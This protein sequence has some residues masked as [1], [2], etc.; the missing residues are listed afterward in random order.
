MSKISLLWFRQLSSI[1]NSWRKI[2][3]DSKK[4]ALFIQLSQKR[5][6]VN[7]MSFVGRVSLNFLEN[8]ISLCKLQIFTS[9]S[10]NLSKSSFQSFNL[11]QACICDVELRVQKL[12]LRKHTRCK[13]GFPEC[14]D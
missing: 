14:L 11:L 8:S 1:D 7:K 3:F 9:L 2:I 6:F 10:K 12:R 4:L 5:N 13:G